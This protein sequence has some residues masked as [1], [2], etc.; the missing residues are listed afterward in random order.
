MNTIM[1]IMNFI[2]TMPVCARLSCIRYFTFLVF[3]SLNWLYSI[4]ILHTQLWHSCTAPCKDFKVYMCASKMVG[5]CDIINSLLV[6]T[7]FHVP[8]RRCYIWTTNRCRDHSSTK[9]GVYLLNTKFS[10]HLLPWGMSK[11]GPKYGFTLAC[12]AFL[13]CLGASV[14]CTSVNTQPKRIVKTLRSSRSCHPNISLFQMSDSD[15]DGMICWLAAEHWHSEGP[16]FDSQQLHLSILPL[17]LFYRS[18][19]HD[20][21]GLSWPDLIN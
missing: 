14:Y 17:S 9:T 20:L 8:S 7:S 2:S 18:H 10:S 11:I 19:R 5:G 6:K 16:G 13:Q 12:P 21:L 15:S 3:A 4:Q 1:R